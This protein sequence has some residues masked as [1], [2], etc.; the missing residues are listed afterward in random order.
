MSFDFPSRTGRPVPSPFQD[1]SV[2]GTIF[3]LMT[4]VADRVIEDSLLC[5][6]TVADR[7]TI[8]RQMAEI[9]AR[10]HAVDFRTVGLADLGRAGDYVSRQVKT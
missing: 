4:F 5:G 7:T 6:F 10:L 2:V 8:Y 3:Y 1:T 9:L